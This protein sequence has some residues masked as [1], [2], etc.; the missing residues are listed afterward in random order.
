MGATRRIASTN[1]SRCSG[2][3]WYSI[4]ISTGPSLG[5]GSAS[6][7]SSG[8]VVPGVTSA[9]LPIRT[10]APRIESTSAS[11]S[12]DETP[13]AMRVSVAAASA[14]HAGLPIA[15]HACT[16]TRFIATALART[17]AGTELCV[18]VERLAWTVT[19]AAP[20]QNVPAAASATCPDAAIRR[21]ASAQR[22]AA[23][24]TTRLSERVLSW[25]GI[26]TA[27]I[28]APTPNIPNRKPYP[29]APSLSWS[30]AITGSSA[31]SALAQAVNESV[32]RM[33]AR[34]VGEW[35]A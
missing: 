14:P 1:A 16:A 4:W 8:G 30:R 20:E 31:Q 10:R 13:R 24:R 11:R 25:R 5:P 7:S 6:I 15:R 17:H 26:E 35:R 23:V 33:N 22:I 29:P 18:P 21:F 12:A 3:I 2:A 27:P 32:R 34:S 9:S 28:T 19:Q